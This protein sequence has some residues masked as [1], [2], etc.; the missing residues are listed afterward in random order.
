MG[1]MAPKLSSDSSFTEKAVDAGIK[2]PVSPLSVITKEFRLRDQ[3]F[4]YMLIVSWF[5]EV[6]SGSNTKRASRMF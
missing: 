3:L 5:N 4:L 1:L 2:E 6:C